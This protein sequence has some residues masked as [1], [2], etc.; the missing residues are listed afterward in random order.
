[1]PARLLAI[2]PGVP[3]GGR[4]GGVPKALKGADRIG[5]DLPRLPASR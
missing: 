5:S 4:V 3:T 2:W 1:M